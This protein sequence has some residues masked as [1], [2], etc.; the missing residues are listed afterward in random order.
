MSVEG[1]AGLPAKPRRRDPSLLPVW[2]RVL[3]SAG[4]GVGVGA[5]VALGAVLT[6]VSA[7]GVPGLA[8]LDVFSDLVAL[9][10]LS[11]LVV[12][13]VHLGFTLGL[14]VVRGRRTP[15]IEAQPDQDGEREPE[16]GVE[17]HVGTEVPPSQG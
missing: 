1:N 14:A 12:F 15:E 13:L 4:W 6:A 5:G 10:W 11:G 17:G 2:R 9:P 7:S 8:G 16:H 3:M